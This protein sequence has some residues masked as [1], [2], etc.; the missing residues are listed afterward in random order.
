MWT[1]SLIE[2]TPRVPI[3]FLK[4]LTGTPG[5]YE[6]R[7]QHSRIAVRMFCF[8]EKKKLVVLHGF[9]KKSVKTPRKEIILA[10]QLKRQYEEINHYNT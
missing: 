3:Q 8:F 6:V 2:E 1:L 5:L 10:L 4:Q 9:V 7:V